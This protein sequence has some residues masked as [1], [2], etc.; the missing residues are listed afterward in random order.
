LSTPIEL[1][2]LARGI[3]EHFTKE[4][5]EPAS[6]GDALT[7]VFARFEQHTAIIV[8]EAGYQGLKERALYLT[9]VNLKKDSALS[10]IDLSRLL[11]QGWTVTVEQRGKLAACQYASVLLGQVFALLGNFIGDVLT[12]RL[13][14][15]TWTELDLAALVPLGGEGQLH[16]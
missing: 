4:L 13:V 3:I 14:S 12:V 11:D 8:G 5:D 2:Q 1:G 15:R 10:S 9:R 16:E 6:V 7:T